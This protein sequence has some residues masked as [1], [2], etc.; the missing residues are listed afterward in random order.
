MT[1]LFMERFDLYLD[2]RIFMTKYIF[3]ILQVCLDFNM[4]LTFNV[5]I[6]E[7]YWNWHNFVIIMDKFY[8]YLDKITQQN[9]HIKYFI[10]YVTLH[11]LLQIN[12]SL[13]RILHWPNMNFSGH[14]K[15]TLRLHST[16]VWIGALRSLPRSVQVWYSWARYVGCTQ[17]QEW[18][19]FP[20]KTQTLVS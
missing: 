18:N 1:L 5:L 2:K 4:T 14:K 17:N 16:K 20:R 8:W 12:R 9:W 7:F 19:S 13:V 3:S 10:Q 6:I 11:N 15:W